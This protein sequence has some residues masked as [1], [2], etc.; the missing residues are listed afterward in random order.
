LPELKES[1]KIL[2]KVGLHA[3]PAA[4]FVKVA[5]CYTSEILIEKD[6][7]TVNAKSIIGV[8]SM[9][10]EQNTVIT[11]KARGEDAEQALRA[12]VSIVNNKLGES[13]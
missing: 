2:N 11:I 8:L 9:G 12:L 1:V 10:I 3:R 13:E 4:T 6:G 7:K 5:N